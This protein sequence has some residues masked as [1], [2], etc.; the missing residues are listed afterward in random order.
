[1]ARL[2]R[3]SVVSSALPH[4]RRRR[5]FSVGSVEEVDGLTE[6]LAQAGHPVVSGPRTTGAGYYESVVRDTEADLVEITV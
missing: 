3:R 6:R 5:A 1:M 2:T 4:V